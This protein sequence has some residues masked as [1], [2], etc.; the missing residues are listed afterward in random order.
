V[1]ACVAEEPRPGA[2]EALRSQPYRRFFGANALTSTGRAL[3]M[4]I[5]GYI[6]FEQT[7]SNFLLGLFSFMQMAPA[8][9]LAPLVGVIVDAFE[10]RRI[11]AVIFAIQS[12]GFLTLTVLEFSGALSVPLIGVLVVIMGTAMAFSFPA[13]SALVP[14]LIPRRALQSAI[15]ANSMMMNT[16][17]I[18]A[19]ALAGFAISAFGVGYVLASGIGLYLP[20]IFIVLS[21]P[22]TVTAAAAPPGVPLRGPAKFFGDLRDVLGYIRANRMLRSALFNDVVPFGFGMAYIAL[23]PSLALDVLGGDA[24]TLG[25]LYGLGGAGSLV[26]TFSGAFVAGRIPRGL[27]IWS[28]MLGWGVALAAIA[29]S[30]SYYVVVPALTL[31]GFFQT[32]YVVQNDTLVQ[33]FAEDRYRGRVIAAQSMINALRTLGFLLIGT[34]ASLFSVPLAIGAFGLI[35]AAMGL[36]TLLF[37]PEMRSLR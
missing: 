1:E 14:M 23:L 18:A 3:Q 15:A 30:S 13:S 11:L 2:F 4:T 25:L 26:G 32:L 33:V 36:A 24:G 21:I 7:A 29:I 10:R 19:P 6:V 27:V 17:R 28:G 20:A 8:L 34:L 22:L 9:V 5:F 35:V 31:T 16:S 37:R 12:A